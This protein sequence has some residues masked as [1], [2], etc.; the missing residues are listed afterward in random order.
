MW[1]HLPRFVRMVFGKVA[2]P[3]W[4]LYQHRFVYYWW[5]WCSTNSSAP[6]S[7]LRNA[8]CKPKVLTEKCYKRKHSVKC[9]IVE[10]CLETCLRMLFSITG[11]LLFQWFKSSKNF[12]RNTKS[13]PRYPSCLFVRFN[14]RPFPPTKVYCVSEIYLFETKGSRWILLNQYVPF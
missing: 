2:R 5:W 1:L 7:Y 14:S 11:F 10:I 12:F 13:V 8:L 6:F 3:H 4:T 9:S